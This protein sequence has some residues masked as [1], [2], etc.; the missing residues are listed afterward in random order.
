MCEYICFFTRRCV[1]V[2]VCLFKYK[3]KC[4]FCE[5]VVYVPMRAG[6]CT[7]K[8]VYVCAFCKCDMCICEFIY[9]CIHTTYQSRCVIMCPRVYVFISM[10]VCVVVVI[11]SLHT[12]MYVY[13]HTDLGIQVYLLAPLPWHQAKRHNSLHGTLNACFHAVHLKALLVCQTVIADASRLV[14]SLTPLNSSHR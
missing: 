9:V 5:L 4:V 14:S 1:Y 10:C 8:C 7:C 12:R 2:D 11:V 6:A 3:C 13:I